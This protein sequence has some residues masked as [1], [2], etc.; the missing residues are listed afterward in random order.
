MLASGMRKTTKRSSIQY[1]PCHSML[2][3]MTRM[4]AS[5]RITS[6]SATLRINP[7]DKLLLDHTRQPLTADP[8]RVNEA[9]A[10]GRVI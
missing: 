5:S 6:S 10:I 1:L 2:M 9:I 7:T 3:K 8:I 4:G